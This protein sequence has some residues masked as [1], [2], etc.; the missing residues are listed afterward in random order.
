MLA[1]V[2][3]ADAPHAARATAITSS[4]TSALAGEIPRRQMRMRLATATG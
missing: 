1:P 4:D 3:G 2:L